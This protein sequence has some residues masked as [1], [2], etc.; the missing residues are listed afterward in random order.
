MFKKQR[1]AIIV[2]PY[3]IGI[4]LHFYIFNV[5]GY[6]KES[7]L[8]ATSLPAFLLVVIVLSG[9]FS[10]LAFSVIIGIS[11]IISVIKYLLNL[12]RPLEIRSR[13]FIK[14]FPNKKTFLWGIL[15]ST[16][17]SMY[18]MLFRLISSTSCFR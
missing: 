2:M 12:N 18:I 11:L 3:L 14:L 15:I 5:L 7:T 17:L 4:G 13:Y 1:M 9:A 10:I 16:Y 6:G 8:G